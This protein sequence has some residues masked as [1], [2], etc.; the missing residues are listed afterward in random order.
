MH[1][2]VGMLLIE[3][4]QATSEHAEAAGPGEDHAWNRLE[5]PERAVSHHQIK[6]RT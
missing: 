1:S 2:V 3:A 4:S 5:C 6:L